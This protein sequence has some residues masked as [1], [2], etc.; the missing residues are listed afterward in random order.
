[1]PQPLLAKQRPTS[2]FDTYQLWSNDQLSGQ[3]LRLYQRSHQQCAQL[4]AGQPNIYLR[5]GGLAAGSS[6][7]SSSGVYTQVAPR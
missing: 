5:K 3:R 2:P 1:M 4:S 6:S 7:S